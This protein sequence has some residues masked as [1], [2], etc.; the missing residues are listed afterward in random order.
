MGSTIRLRPVD[1]DPA[2]NCEDIGRTALQ[3]CADA[4]VSMLALSEPDISWVRCAARHG[5]LYRGMS[6]VDT[7]D[8]RDVPPGSQP[9]EARLQCDEGYNS[10]TFDDTL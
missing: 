6:T 1:I 10:V 9:G 7:V 8:P 4:G 2:P 3:A 5:L